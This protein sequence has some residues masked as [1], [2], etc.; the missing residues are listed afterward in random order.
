MNIVFTAS[1]SVQLWDK[2]I[3]KTIVLRA[4][5]ATFI[6]NLTTSYKQYRSVG[7]ISPD[8]MHVAPT[9]S[10]VDWGPAGAKHNS[11]G[12]HHPLLSW[13]EQPYD[14]PKSGGSAHT[15]QTGK[16]K[17]CAHVCKEYQYWRHTSIQT[18]SSSVVRSTQKWFIHYYPEQS[19]SNSIEKPHLTRKASEMSQWTILYT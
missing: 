1:Y 8:K 16:P 19:V 12:W 14:L 2:V 4:Y 10:A 18:S 5:K 9:G 6:W 11:S 3:I 7:E 15:L 13:V 17:R